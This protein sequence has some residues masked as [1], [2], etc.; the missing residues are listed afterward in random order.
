M[1]T[2][3]ED[4]LA[5]ALAECAREP[6]HIPGAIQSAGCLIC[7]D[8]HLARV[9]QVSKNLWEFLGI[10]ADEA[11]R[12]APAHSLG[13]ALI[14]GLDAWLS[15]D[16]G[17]RVHHD[18]VKAAGTDQR[19]LATA[20]RSGARVVVEIEPLSEVDEREMLATVRH[21]QSRLIAQSREPELLQVLVEAIRGLTQHDRVLVYSFDADWNGQVKAESRSDRLDSLLGHRFP[22]SDIPSQ[23]RALYDINPI[24]SIPDAQASAVPLVPEHCPISGDPLDL[25]IGGLR[26]VSPVHQEYLHNMGVAAALS[27]AMQTDEGLWGLVACHGVSAQVVSP[28]A[29]DAVHMLVMMAVQRLQLLRLKVQQDFRQRVQDSRVLLSEAR[30]ELMG[31]SDLIQRH[32]EGWM[33]LFQSSGVGLVYGGTVSRVGSLPDVAT[34]KQVA[35]W[36]GDNHSGGRAW[37]SS[38]LGETPLGE[39]V[40]ASC[41][42]GLLAVPLLVDVDRR[43]WLMLFREE[44][45][46]LHR[47]A[48]RPQDIPELRDGRLIM[49]PRRSFEAWQQELTGHSAPWREAEDL[50]AQDL[51]EDLAVAASASEISILNESLYRERQALAEANKRL[52]HLAHTD[53]LTQIWNRYRL[54]QA[55]EAE[56]NAASRYGRNVSVLLFDIDNFKSVND[57]FGHEVGDQVL[58][59]LAQAVWK[60]LRS[61]DAVGRWGGEEFLVLCTGCAEDEAMGLA[62]RLLKNVS[63]VEFD[64]V[65]HVTISIGVASWSEGESQ[66]ELINRADKAMYQAKEQGRNR[67]I[68][69]ESS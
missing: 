36:L 54:E 38:A 28:V 29:R 62:Q 13:E 6:V 12:C 44:H 58:T 57:R 51:A 25:S 66:A 59:G 33:T 37:H 27:I 64:T 16:S 17:E 9:L 40:D 69:S 55:L 14:A 60:T 4:Q 50:A 10:S 42:C 24:R 45:R 65:G 7:L 63:E 3:T 23:V 61:S 39:W 2:Y 56:L 18:V 15:A 1:S 34:L 48:G 35:T 46:E 5:D 53:P 8:E 52:E 20:Y 21:W 26:A 19:C 11:L 49:S 47:W 31:A 32:G 68:K 67:A 22:A 41:S 30:G 43:G